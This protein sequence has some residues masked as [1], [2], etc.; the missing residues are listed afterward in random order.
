MLANGISVGVHVCGH[1]STGKHRL[2]P[3]T[4][5]VLLYNNLVSCMENLPCWFFNIEEGKV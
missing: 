4:S 2:L 1:R 5:I 3:H